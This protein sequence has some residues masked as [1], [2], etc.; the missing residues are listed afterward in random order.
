M[1]V[2]PVYLMC[3][4]MSL[5]KQLVESCTSPWLPGVPVPHRR[6]APGGVASEHCSA[7]GPPTRLQRPCPARPPPCCHSAPMS[8]CRSPVT[9]PLMFL[10]IAIH[11]GGFM[12]RPAAAG[13]C[14]AAHSSNIPQPICAA[15]RRMRLHDGGAFWDSVFPVGYF[16]GCGTFEVLV[17]ACS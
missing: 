17:Q 11:L 10:A 13:Q 3:Q 16:V 9:Q 14:S 5:Y 2:R 7:A 15:A 1:Q 8:S 6:G 4:H 12:H